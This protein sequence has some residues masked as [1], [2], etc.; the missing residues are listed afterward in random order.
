[1]RIVDVSAFYSPAGGGV[2]TYVEAKLKAA[3]RFGHEIIVLVPGDRDEV[4]HR[5]QGAV[6]ARIASPTLPVDRR[7]RYFDDQRALHRALDH[8]RPD[9]VEASSPWSSATM[10]GRWQGAATR[11][12][13]MHADPL[14]A[15]A[16]R[17]LGGIIPIPTID[18][19]FG[20]FWRHMRGLGRMFDTVICAN[21]QLAARLGAAGV[22]NVETI[23]MGVE[24]GRFSPR[25]RSPELRAAALASLGLGPEAALLVG[26]GRFSA[27]KRWEMVIRAV[28]S[29]ARRRPIGLL[30][31]G[32]GPRRAK[33]ELMACRAG[34]VGVLPRLDDRHEVARLMA[35]ADALVHGCEAETFCLVAAEARASGTPMIIP[36][37]GA[38]LDLLAPHAGEA[39]R[40]G[41]ERSLESA[42]ARFVEG[43]VELQRAAA[44][45]ASSLRSM[46]QHFADL[47]AHYGAV[48]LRAFRPAAGGVTVDT[49]LVPELALARSAVT[50]S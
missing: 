50:R 6:L 5:G 27:E 36:D 37:R 30:L 38:A 29:C 23:T 49:A 20:A 12:L 10:V 41:N 21:G 4:E 15:Y 11:S 28:E 35:S 22:E 17:W 47:F 18:R 34:T 14:A 2:R 16:Y 7:Y 40:A 32:D 1:M 19:W 42:I 24:P 39:Y 33:L 13:V 26:M 45:R 3:S 9:H 31:I 8:W 44:V 25:L 43:G 46:D 48:G